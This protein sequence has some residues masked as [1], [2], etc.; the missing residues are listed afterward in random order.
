MVA[1][2]FAVLILVAGCSSAPAPQSPARDGAPQGAARSPVVSVPPAAAVEADDAGA[3]HETAEQDEGLRRAY[4]NA[5]AGHRPLDTG[6]ADTSAGG[7]DGGASVDAGAG[8]CQLDWR[9]LAESSPAR[10]ALEAWP[11][12]EVPED[13]PSDFDPRALLAPGGC[14]LPDCQEGRM[15][16]GKRAVLRIDGPNGSGHFFWLGLAV[17]GRTPR[18]ACMQASTVAWRLLHPVARKISPLPWLADVDGD[19][20][21]ELVAWQRLPW[22]QSEVENG[23]APTVYQLDGDTLVRRDAVGGGLAARVAAAYRELAGMGEEDG[24]PACYQAMAEV[25]DRWGA[26]P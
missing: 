17:D 19:R 21:A 15:A 18:F 7:D 1:R 16:G 4:A 2:S 24:F 9:D 23:L 5:L 14:A 8:T 22:G 3:S 6:P 25:L 20:S 26:H 12:K 10:I 13:C 11:P